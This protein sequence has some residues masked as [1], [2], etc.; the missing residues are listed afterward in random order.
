MSPD[1]PLEREGEELQ[2]E[3][4]PALLSNG[5]GRGAERAEGDRGEEGKTR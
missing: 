2:V 1:P 3:V 5:K 4:F